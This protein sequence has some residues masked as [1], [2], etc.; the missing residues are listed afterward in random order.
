MKSKMNLA[1]SQKKLLFEAANALRDCGHPELAEELMGSKDLSLI[2]REIREQRDI[3]R[4]VQRGRFLFA[5][6]VAVFA[7]RHKISALSQIAATALE[8]IELRP[9]GDGR[10][11]IELVRVKKAAA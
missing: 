7:G 9:L 8:G 5:N 11:L 1:V 4:G 3:I 6:N 10:F 2:A